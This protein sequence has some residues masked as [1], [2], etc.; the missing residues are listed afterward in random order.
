LPHLSTEHGL[1]S[2]PLHHMPGSQGVRSPPAP[3]L[4]TPYSPTHYTLHLNP[5]ALL[6]TPYT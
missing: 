5:T 2:Q 4:P 1:P 6:T 3:P